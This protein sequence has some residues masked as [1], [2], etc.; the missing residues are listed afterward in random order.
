MLLPSFNGYITSE[1]TIDLLRLDVFISQIAKVEELLLKT[2]EKEKES[3]KKR[4]Q[5]KTKEKLS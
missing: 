3:L 5:F 4:E 1:G 2:L